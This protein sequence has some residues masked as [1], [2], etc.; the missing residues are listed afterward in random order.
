MGRRVVAYRGGG[1]GEI[2]SELQRVGGEALARRL[3]CVDLGDVAA[4]GNQFTTQLIALLVQ[5]Y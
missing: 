4:L 2:E 5:K 1:I 3:V